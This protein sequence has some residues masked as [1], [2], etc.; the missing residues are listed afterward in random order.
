MTAN[1]VRFLG[2][3]DGKKLE[4]FE[5]EPIHDRNVISVL[6]NPFF[7]RVYGCGKA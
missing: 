5:W 3:S 1:H 2:R 6:E 4:N 7:V